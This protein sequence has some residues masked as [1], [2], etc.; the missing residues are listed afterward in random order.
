LI[1]I[2]FS[3]LLIIYYLVEDNA[4][5]ITRQLEFSITKDWIW[6]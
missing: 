4:A 2:G 6:Y 5:M 3:C 1:N